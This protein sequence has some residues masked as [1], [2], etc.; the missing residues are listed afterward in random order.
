MSTNTKKE[1][2]YMPENT[3][4]T[5]QF[6]TIRQA[7]EKLNVSIKTLRRWEN[8][9][10]VHPIRNEQN[11][12]LYA[13]IEISNLENRKYK[14]LP[15]SAIAPQNYQ[16]ISEAAD[17][18]GVSV[19]TL[20]RWDN[21]GKISIPRDE[22]NRRTFTPD[23]IEQI[24]QERPTFSNPNLPTDTQLKPEETK[25]PTPT[26]TTPPIARVPRQH[27]SRPSFALLPALL[28]P[29][30]SLLPFILV[31]LP[32]LLF[33]ALGYKPSLPVNSVNFNTQD[34]QSLTLQSLDP[35]ASG[36]ATVSRDL[37]PLLSRPEAGEVAGVT[38]SGG[39]LLSFETILDNNYNFGVAGIIEGNQLVSTTTVKAP[40]IVASQE[41]VINLNADLLDGHSWEEIQTVATTPLGLQGSYDAGNTIVTSVN[42]LDITLTGTTRFAVGGTGPLVF[43]TTGQTTFASNIDA[44][45]GIDITGGDLT[46]GAS[47]LVAEVDTGNLTV[48]GD[49]AINGGDLTSTATSV[50]LFNSTT[51]TVNLG[52]SATTLSIGAGTGTTTINHALT[53]A[54][55]LTA[56][57]EV[58]LG[59]S[60][61]NITLNASTANLN[62]INTISL[63]PNSDNDDYI[64]FSTSSNNPGLFFAG[65]A[66]TNDPGIRVNSATGQME[67]RDQ[68][69]AT[70]LPFGT[71]GSGVWTDGGTYIRPTNNESVRIYDAS[72]SYYVDI[73]HDGSNVTVNTSG[74]SQVQFDTGI[75]LSGALT[76]PSG[77]TITGSGNFAQLSKGLSVG[78]ANTYF[79]NQS[80]NLYTNIATISGTLAIS[81]LSQMSSDN[82]RVLTYDTATGLIQYLDTTSWDKDTADDL[83][84][85][86][87]N[88]WDQNTWDDITFSNLATA[89]ASILSAWDQDS[90]DDLS[91]A[92]SYSGDVSG[93]YDNLQLGSG[94]VGSTEIA[95]SSIAEVDLDITNAPSDGYL[96]QTD[97]SGNLTWIDPTSLTA[98][99]GLFAIT[100]EQI[101]PANA[102]THDLL[103]G[104]TSTASATIA[105]QA[106]SGNLKATSAD[107]SSVRISGT[108]IGL[109]SDTDL[110]SLADSL[111][112]INGHVLPGTDATYDLG[113][114]TS[115]FRD[116][117]LSGSSIHLGTDSNEAVISYD[118]VSDY[119]ALNPSSDGT[120]EF[121]LYDTGNLEIDGSASVTAL[122]LNGDQILSSATELNLLSGHTGT[123]LDTNNVLTELSTWDMNIWDDITF[124]NMATA[125]ASILSGWDQN[126]ADDLTLADTD[127]WDMNI[128]DDIT[129]D[130]LATSAASILSAWDQDSS[131]DLTTATNFSG[132]VSGA[133]DNL[134]LGSAVV[135]SAELDF[136]T[137]TGWD[138]NIWDDIT[139]ANLATNAASILSAWDQNASDDYV[140]PMT[141]QGD[142]IY[143]GASGVATRLPGAGTDN[144]VLKY[145]LDTNTPY[146]GT[147]DGG[148][149]YT[150]SN[151][152]TLVGADI[153]LDFSTFT[154]WDQ[155]IWDDITFDNMATAAA[156]ILSAWDQDSS[157]DLTTATSFSGDV[158][159]TYDNLQLGAAV[160][161]SNELD[162]ATFTNWDQNI[163]DDITFGNMATAA[164]SILSAW[165]QD[166]SN[167]L[168]TTD[169]G[170]TVQGYNA[171]TSFLGQ[172]I[173][174]S[175][176]DPASFL[177]WDMNIW[178][179]ITVDNLATSAASI[180][181]AWDQD[182]SNDLTTAT[183]FSGDVSGTYDNLQLGSAVVGSN[184]LDYSAFTNWDQNIWDD[185]TFSNLATSAASI[186]SAWDQNA[187][188][189]Y[190]NPMTTQG[191]IIYGGA[192]GVATR[193]AGSSTDG[194]V[195]KY[196][197]STNEPYWAVDEIGTDTTYTGSNGITLVGNDFQLD[198][199][200]FTGWDQNIWDDITFDNMA[201]AAASILSAW[202]QDASNDLTTAT[203]FSGDV[204]G[205]YDNLQLGSAVVGS[206]EL[207]YATFT[208]W[209][210]NIWD[211]I[212]F[213]NMATAAASI[214]SAWDQDSSNDLTTATSFSGDVSGTYDNLQLGSAVVGSNELDYA[215]FTGWD[216]NIWD[217]ITT[218]NLATSAAS[219][220]SAWDQNSSDDLTTAT[221]FSGDVSGT[222][223]N[224]QLGSAVVGSTELDFST[225]T[226]WDQNIGMILPPL[227]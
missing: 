162:Y 9:G 193:L 78:G 5:N 67:Y 93:T 136:A 166:S 147:D 98:G 25:T 132:D 159:G 110:I 196:N 75:S 117:Y 118:T 174:T 109:S 220:L 27:R 6:L 20:R 173:D 54:G 35:T 154:G 171:D 180:L 189:D 160:V 106:I 112:T 89:A 122:Y 76:L 36:S 151:G 140:N 64:Y 30:L 149:S 55:T 191:D 80:G 70:W 43:S 56:N 53:I 215:T 211:D 223:D 65:I 200:T 158:S 157:N 13:E 146:W 26:I 61:D 37:D 195:L 86:S 185:I 103:I 104:G 113:S 123:L 208:G 137:F 175:E 183:S 11:Q 84:L 148:T 130:N 51:S 143:S 181:S 114:S 88:G 194:W 197:T 79:F 225:F 77:N 142:I 107:I 28:T 205:T 96:L 16:S 34:G 10:L 204:S 49:L 72:G 59:D 153:Q 152:V 24:K 207:D 99:G 150:A 201:T 66:A 68:N 60:G 167:D 3:A 178:D 22:L 48:A 41:K 188:D 23:L 95:D 221:S 52:G 165:D 226:G 69:N 141:T 163:W 46:V 131:N 176:L 134:Q 139:T 62:A 177:T 42:D 74:A 33:S 216:Q 73:A 94:V 192:S 121:I 145:D 217:D 224:L 184:E 2:R 182:S 91:T 135:G 219:I 161:G 50:N 17:A 218:A 31:A 210:Q 115:R 144:F 102:L 15:E 21:E 124:D 116:L 127:T 222:Y 57:G 156:S 199:S 206:S 172:T 4:T 155:N 39:S 58:I 126:A 32:I 125:A 209:D 120:P 202:D 81:T 203:S 105:L 179:D 29:L 186:L 19:K 108:T 44:Q 128:W 1:S 168:I 212:T 82:Q 83:D 129:F 63:K 170:V 92:T 45:S 164:A 8:H 47:K 100:N 7:A 40:L 138:Q 111:V 227:T 14:P 101:H 12:R 38:V 133:Y 71:G 87:T 85:S 90:S 187:S 213:G 119:L 214:L 190:V 169:I 198:F 97:A 18:V